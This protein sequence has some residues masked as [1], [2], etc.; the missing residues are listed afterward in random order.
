MK[1]QEIMTALTEIF[2]TVF[3]DAALAITP[4]TTPEDIEEWDS[5]EQINLLTAAQERFGVKFTLEDVR[6]IGS[7]GDI[8]ALVQ[9]ALEGAA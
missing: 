9:R 5:L 1:E 3:D 7:V 8:A 2:R 4:K 6:H